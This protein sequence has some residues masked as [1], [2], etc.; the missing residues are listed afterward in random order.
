MTVVLPP[1][2]VTWNLDGLDFNVGADAYGHSAIVDVPEWDAPAGPKPKI[3]ERNEA[4]GASQGPNYRAGK[5]LRIQGTGQ[6]ASLSAREDFRDRLAGMM[7]DENTFYPLT[8]H[9]PYRSSDLTMW[10]KLNDVPDF[11]RAPDG[12]SLTIDIPLFAS[13]PW[14]YSPDNTPQS[15]GLATSGIDGILWNGSPAVSGG[16]E[17]NGSPTVTGGLIYES[18]QGSTGV[19]RLTNSGT[20]DAPISFVISATGVNPQ[21][22]AIQTQQRIRWVG[23][24]NTGNVLS[25]DT[26]TGSVTLGPPGS[27]TPVNVAAGLSDSQFFLVPRKGFLDVA[28]TAL[29]GSGMQLSGT[30]KNVYA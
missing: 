29:S 13:D 20:R 10:V 3:V 2:P 11:R 26:G 30:N 16:I 28:F 4:H 7:L 9:N 17:W 21:L 14:K 5:S 8:C 15:T 6:A 24:I 12:V 19:I 23:T 27:A 1:L 25:I 18:A 22:V